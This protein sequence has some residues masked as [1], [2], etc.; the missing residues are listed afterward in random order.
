M[1]ELWEYHGTHS[2]AVYSGATPIQ[3]SKFSLLLTFLTVLAMIGSVRAQTGE[4]D[5]TTHLEALRAALSAGNYLDAYNEVFMLTDSAPTELTEALAAEPETEAASQTHVFLLL[6]SGQP[7]QALVETGALPESHF[8]FVAEAAAYEILGNEDAA[9]A[10]KLGLDGAPDE[11]QFYGLMAAAAFVKG[12][13]EA[14]LENSEFAIELNPGLA[15]A[16]RLRGIGKLR[17]GDPKAAL[18]DANHAIELD[19]SVYFFHYLRANIHFA[20]GD[21]EAALVDVNAA[22]AINTHS[23]LGHA[24]RSNANLALNNEP[25]AAQDF[26]RAIQVRTSEIVDVEPLVDIEPL[27][28]TMTFGRTFHLPVE[29]QSGQTLSINVLNVNPDVVDPIVLLISPDGV[30]LT[31]NDDASDE[32][33]DAEIMEYSLPESG[34]YTVIVS[35][36]NGGSEGNITITI[37]LD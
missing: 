14:V 16:Y 34:I 6:F 25:Q 1:N 9:D 2:A 32:T 28:L 31:F 10:F 5:G 20:L 3:W 12:D 19:P 17:S 4:F 24:M 33:L 18:A 26:A 8:T 22:L 15:S 35:H 23:F 36:A 13:P 21:P 27:P 30:P 11:G 29:A 37:S 7:V